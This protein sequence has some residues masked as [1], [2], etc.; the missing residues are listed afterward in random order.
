VTVLPRFDSNTRDIE[1]KIEANVA[2]LVPS[3]S[4]TPLPG[5]NISKLSTLVHLKLGQS[6]VLSG[7]RTRSQRHDIAGLPLL[8][9]IPLLGVFFGSHADQREDVEGA[10]F[11]IPSVIESVPNYTADMIKNAMSRFEDYSGDVD[12]VKTF[13]KYPTLNAPA[14]EK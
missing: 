5:R 14:S 4:N 8:S 12:R 9:Q 1:I 10:V 13:D 2:D 11:V 3:A 6:L 7:I